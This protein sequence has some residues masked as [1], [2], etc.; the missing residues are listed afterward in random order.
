MQQNSIPYHEVDILIPAQQLEVNFSYASTVTLNF[1][2]SMVLRLVKL[3]PM[4]VEEIANFLGINQREVTIVLDDLIDKDEIHLTQNDRFNLTSKSLKYFKSIDSIPNVDSILEHTQNFIYE[5]LSFNVVN[6]KLDNQM[7]GV[8]IP[9]NIESAASSEAKVRSIFQDQFYD[10]IEDGL[11]TLKSTGSNQPN[12]Y[13]MGAVK[14]IKDCSIRKPLDL[15]MDISAIPLPIDGISEISTSALEDHVLK[16]IGRVKKGSNVGEITR[17][18]A[19]FES[20]GLNKYFENEKFQPNKILNDVIESFITKD[21]KQNYMFVGPCYSK[22]NSDIL[23]NKIRGHCEDKKF[24]QKLYW[25]APSDGF[26]GKSQRF[27]SFVDSLNQVKSKNDKLNVTCYLP[28]SDERDNFSKSNY[29]NIL[30]RNHYH[31]FFGIKDDILNG[32]FEILLLENEFVI[33]IIHIQD[34]EQEFLTSFPI[35]V[36]SHDFELTQSLTQLFK[37]WDQKIEDGGRNFGQ[38]FKK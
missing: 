1:I 36:I 2:D 10:L 22:G 16:T 32:D 5:L 17:N 25:L 8:K 23:L 20:L 13:K 26:W 15:N 7:N 31:N 9:L 35:G 3:S 37:Q 21:S 11:L 24:Q 33:V 19:G 34:S 27:I 29:R 38:I 14:K 12:I 4:T 18:L 28:L 30:D 6:K